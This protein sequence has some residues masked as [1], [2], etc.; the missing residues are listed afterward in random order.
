MTFEEWRIELER[1]LGISVLE[2]TRIVARLTWGHGNDR[3]M[4]EREACLKLI[5]SYRMHGGPVTP[6]GDSHDALINELMRAIKERA[7][8]T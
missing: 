7:R 1:L 2:D 5:D 4:E 3:I 6:M 8:P